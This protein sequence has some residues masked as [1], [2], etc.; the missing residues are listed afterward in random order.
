VCERERPSDTVWFCFIAS[1]LSCCFSSFGSSQARGGDGVCAGNG[2]FPLPFVPEKHERIA[3]IKIEI[4]VY[5]YTHILSPGIALK[6]CPHNCYAFRVYNVRMT[7]A[8]RR[9][10]WGPV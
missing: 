1:V 9:G 3:K 8:C 10:I 2:L 4:Y 7:G 6:I 5:I